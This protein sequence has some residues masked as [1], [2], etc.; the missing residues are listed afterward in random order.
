MRRLI[1]GLCHYIFAL[2][3]TV[4]CSI[5]MYFAIVKSGNEIIQIITKL[6]LG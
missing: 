1:S 6:Y 4:G 5:A 3:A 2:L